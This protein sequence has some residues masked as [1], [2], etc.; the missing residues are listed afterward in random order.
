MNYFMLVRNVK[1][2][3]DKTKGK[4][5]KIKVVKGEG[6]DLAVEF[7]FLKKFYGVDVKSISKEKFKIVFSFVNAFIMSTI[8]IILMYLLDSWV[9]R[10][11]VGIVLLGLLIVICY[12]FLARYCLWKEGDK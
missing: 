4:K 3:D 9:L 10:I 6:R 2:D 5:S 7:M 8:Y 1:I 12:G 11:V